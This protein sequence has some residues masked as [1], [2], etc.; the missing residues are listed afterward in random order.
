MDRPKYQTEVISER[1]ELSN[2]LNALKTFM[3]T[4]VYQ[5]LACDERVLLILQADAMNEYLNILNM[6][7]ATFK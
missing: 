1:I 5:A 6:R 7:I 2:K 3:H 4:N